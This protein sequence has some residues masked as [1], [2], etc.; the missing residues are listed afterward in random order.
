MLAAAVLRQERNY[1]MPKKMQDDE[2]ERYAQVQKNKM[3]AT[4]QS[5]PYY[6]PVSGL[7][8]AKNQ[9]NSSQTILT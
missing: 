4:A 2:S 7:Q 8:H 9:V 1:E 3:F 5:S 6:Q